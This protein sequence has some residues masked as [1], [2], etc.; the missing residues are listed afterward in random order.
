MKY[1]GQTMKLFDLIYQGTFEIFYLTFMRID[2]LK[3][4]YL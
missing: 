4:D 3:V 2:V 1:A